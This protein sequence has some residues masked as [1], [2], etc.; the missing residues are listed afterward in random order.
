MRVSSAIVSLG[1]LVGRAVAPSGLVGRAVAPS[2]LVGRAVAPSAA[3][4]Y[5]DPRSG[6][7]K[8]RKIVIICFPS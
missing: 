5:F 8:D 7:V 6:K 2:G 3:V 4:R 1:G